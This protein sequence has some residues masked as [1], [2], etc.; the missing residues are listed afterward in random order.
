MNSLLPHEPRFVWLKKTCKTYNKPYK[1][2]L[3]LFGR[4]SCDLK[5]TRCKIITINK[6]NLRVLDT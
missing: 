3:I 5:E 4:W 1:N 6:F 2:S